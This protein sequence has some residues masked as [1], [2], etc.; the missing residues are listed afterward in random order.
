MRT[1][2]CFN[3]RD[4]GAKGDG[5]ASDTVAIQK[6]LD[7]AGAASGTVWFPAGEYLCHDLKV[8]ER[9]CLRADPAWLYRNENAGAVLRLDDPN[10][11]CL[12]DITGS[13]GVHLYG[14]FLRGMRSTPKPVHGVLLDNP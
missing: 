13:F 9:V 10:A 2:T 3:V 12:L 6:A 7:A 11:R 8:P 4:F 5:K 1:D 14:L